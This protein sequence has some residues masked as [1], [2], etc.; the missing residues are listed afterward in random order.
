MKSTFA[1]SPRQLK[2]AALIGSGV[3]GVARLR[4]VH[5][6]SILAYHGICQG[7]GDERVLDWSLHLPQDIFRRVCA[8]LASNYQVIPLR[9]LIACLEA[10]EKPPPNAVVLTFDDG[11]ASNFH[12]A[13]PVLREF[14]LPATIFVTTGFLDGTEMLWFQRVDLALGR[15]S[16]PHLDWKF[17]HGKER[18]P[19]GTREQRRHALTRLLTALKCLPDVDFLGEID[20]LERTLGVQEPTLADLPVPMR[21]MTWDQARDMAASSLIEIGGHT[22]TH[23]ILARCDSA[24][25]RGEIVTCRDRITTELG[26]PATDFCYPNGG[27]ADYTA[28]TLSILAETGFKA[29]CTMENGRVQADTPL[30]ELPRYG[31]PESVWEAE[32]TVSGAYETVKEWRQAA[33]HTVMSFLA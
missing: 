6:V 26:A 14:H 18:L 29:A 25:M 5:L 30:L 19:L 1:P 12:L 8:F 27:S 7:M 15:T 23:P 17:E 22:H 24:S 16:K 3:A 33:H 31:S 20:R 10:G 11:Y 32:A 9:E 21:P 13:F 2:A 4:N 28:E